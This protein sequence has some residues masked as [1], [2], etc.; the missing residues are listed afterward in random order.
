[1][2]NFKEIMAEAKT[3]S[4]V[5]VIA[6]DAFAKVEKVD[7]EKTKAYAE[8]L[9]EAILAFMTQET[10]DLGNFITEADKNLAVEEAV[11]AT[12]EE[13]KSKVDKK[14][15][16]FASAL[17]EKEEQITQLT[18]KVNTT[19]A[20]LDEMKNTEADRELDTKVELFVGSVQE[21]GIKLTDGMQK[22]V[23][24]LAKPIIEDEVALEALR[25]ELVATVKQTALEEGSKVM[26]NGTT[27]GGKSA[28]GLGDE[29]KQLREEHKKEIK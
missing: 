7:E 28:T 14:E 21:A 17:S 19:E 1:M 12:K 26:G 20:E 9:S 24:S 6:H 23:A 3:L 8:E 27:G 22:Y 25:T 5:F 16:E 2:F 15:T 11:K 10:C 18:E 29:L 13:E 4:D